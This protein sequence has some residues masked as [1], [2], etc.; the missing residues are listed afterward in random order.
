[1]SNVV[2]QIKESLQ[3]IAVGIEGRELTDDIL[4]SDLGIDSMKYVELLVL[5]EEKCDVVFDESDLGVDALKS[6]G[7]LSAL[8]SKTISQKA[9]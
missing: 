9:G 8:I 6:I 1:M 2:E 5:I 7:D 3:E 4:L